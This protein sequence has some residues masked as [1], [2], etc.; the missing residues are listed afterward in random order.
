MVLYGFS[1]HFFQIDYYYEILLKMSLLSFQQIIRF[2]IQSVKT[3][4]NKHL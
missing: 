2:L 3:T 4:N 1:I